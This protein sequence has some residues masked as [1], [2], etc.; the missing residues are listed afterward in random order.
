MERQTDKFVCRLVWEEGLIL[1]P[2]T[3]SLSHTLGW[4][5][6]ARARP[7]KVLLQS[8]LL[9]NSVSRRQVLVPS[10]EASVSLY[11]R[12]KRIK[13]NVPPPT[14]DEALKLQQITNSSGTRRVPLRL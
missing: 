4:S 1:L 7:K 12:L 6:I 11:S 9:K 2:L 3:K 14:G 8:I 5:S 13:R 10:I